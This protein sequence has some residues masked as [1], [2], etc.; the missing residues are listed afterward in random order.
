MG[1]C[2]WGC[3]VCVCVC[4]SGMEK[5]GVNRIWYAMKRLL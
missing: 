5:E 3:G 4:V 1:N 2:V